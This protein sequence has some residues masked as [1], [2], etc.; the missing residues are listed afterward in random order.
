MSTKQT[1]TGNRGLQ[2]EEP[3]IFEI[4]TADNCGVDLEPVPPTDTRL[5]DC[6]AGVMSICRACQSRKRCAISCA[7][8]RKT[9]PLTPGF[10][11]SARAP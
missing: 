9:M 4:G 2:L 10:I 11:R 5:G 1:F 3:L 6:A 8:A 7:S